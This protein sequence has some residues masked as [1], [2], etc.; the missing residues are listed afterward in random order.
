MLRN[1]CLWETL[2]SPLQRGLWTLLVWPASMYIHTISWNSLCFFNFCNQFIIALLASST[3]LLYLTLFLFLARFIDPNHC[4]LG[5]S[6]I[7]R[8]ISFPHR[9]KIISSWRKLS[10]ILDL[11]M[12]EISP[13]HRALLLFCHVWS[14][15]CSILFLISHILH[16]IFKSCCTSVVDQTWL[17]L[18]YLVASLTNN[19][20]WA[21]SHV[22]ATLPYMKGFHPNLS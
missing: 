8:I 14:L 7:F 22:V 6:S 19:F 1:Q 3:W 16:C 11:N 15:S 4:C 12:L 5:L 21:S 9:K 10:S 20:S 13:S 17:D 18:L 2:T